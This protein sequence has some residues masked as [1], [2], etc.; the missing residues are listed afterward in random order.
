MRMEREKKKRQHYLGLKYQLLM[1]MILITVF[2]V[3]SIIGAVIFIVSDT[4]NQKID[5]ENETITELISK[6]ISAFV[7]KAYQV[8]EELSVDPRILSM[9]TDTQHEL[10]K[11]CN[12]R[13]DYFELMYVQNMKGM[14]TGKSAGELTDRSER[15]WFKKMIK[16]MQPFV[17]QPFFSGTSHKPVTSVFMPLYQNGEAVGIIGSNIKLDYLQEQINQYADENEGRYFFIMDSTGAIIAHPNTELIT[18]LY[19]YKTLTKTVEVKDA[20]GEV[21]LGDNGLPKTEEQTIEIADG[22]KKITEDVINGNSGSLRFA[23]EGINYC[24]SYVP[25]KLPG[26]TEDWSLIAVQKQTN[27]TAIISEIVKTTFITGIIVLVLTSIIILV[28]ANKISAPIIKISKLLTKASAG[29]FTVN[30]NIKAKNEIG[31]LSNSFNEM[32]EKVSHLI[33][34]TQV[35]TQNIAD[36]S[37][38]L[39]TQAEHSKNVAGN[40]TNAVHGIAEGAFQQAADSETSAL[41]MTSIT[42]K[43]DHLTDHSRLMMDKADLSVKVTEEGTRKVKELKEKAEETGKLMGE[44]ETSINNLSSKSQAIESIL[45]TL[46]DIASETKLLSLNASIEAARA[47]EYGRSFTVVAEEIQKLSFESIESTKNIAS[48]I[49]DIQNEI[50]IS[51]KM[52]LDVKSVTEEELDSV[53]NVTEAFEQITDTIDN[54]K[55]NI[56]DMGSYITDMDEDNKKITCSIENISSISEETASESDIVKESL[57][58]QTASIL[59]VAKQSRELQDRAKRLETEIAKFIV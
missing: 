18:Q 8:T 48:I 55:K 9:D 7:E 4:Y 27:A 34:G 50:K 57:S 39:N 26:E 11:A 31:T 53:R 14:Q 58:D 54:I 56:S 6:N 28:F 36:G 52:I 45:D 16:E 47:G 38:I 10:L 29:D 24:A 59:E 15:D 37:E 23:D 3:G 33:K 5:K 19:N 13:N 25:I 2:L 41:L 30:S 32:V 17:Y 40:I 51:V 49:D 22:Y 21:I 44:A 35:L 46:N 43:F 42:E 12:E 20:N 1:T